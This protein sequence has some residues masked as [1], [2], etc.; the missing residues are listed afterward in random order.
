VLGDPA[1]YPRAWVDYLLAN[2]HNENALDMV[3]MDDGRLQ[4]D[5]KAVLAAAE[6][7]LTRNPTDYDAYWSKARALI[8]LGRHHDAIE[9]L[10]VYLKY[11]HN[12]DDYNDAA[13]W[14][15]KISA[16]PVAK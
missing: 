14:L 5:W 10:R 12:E 4:Q 11:S 7:Y 8:E 2:L 16:E 15:K 13:D 3:R 9:P 6:S 1:A